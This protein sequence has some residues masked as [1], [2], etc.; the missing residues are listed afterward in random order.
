[1]KQTHPTRL[2]WLI[3]LILAT[4]AV[5]PAST[6]AQNP[7]QPH[8]VQPGDTWLALAWR[9]QTTPTNLQTHNPFLNTQRQPVIGDTIQVPDVPPQ[10]GRLIPTHSLLQ[11]A[12]QHNQNPWQL[13]LQNHLPHPH[14]PSFGRPL[15]VADGVSL[16]RQLPPQFATLELAQVPAFPGE[17]L[18][19]RGVWQG[20]AATLPTLTLGTAVGTFFH[21]PQNGAMVGLIGTGA[22]FRPGT[23]ELTIRTAGQPLWAQPWRISDQK[24][25]T[26]NQITLSGTAATIT[27]QQRAAER[28]RLFDLWAQHTPAPL[29]N[30]PF[31]EPISDYLSYSS[32]YGA[33]RSYNG[34]PYDSYHEG[35]D[36]AAFGGTEVYAPADGIVVLAEFLDVRGGAVIIDHGLGV[37][38]GFYHLSEVA[39][40]AIG[41]PIAQGE[42]LGAVGTTGLSTGNHLHWDLL[43]NGVWVDPMPWREQNLSAWLLTGWQ[44]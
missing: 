28:E 2:R 25:W 42:T 27:A 41:Q 13:A 30:Q 38:S 10:N 11:T 35:L 36:F 44:Q 33:R 37:F 6:R 23:P 4:T 1:M 39:D 21:N 34:G 3:W 5:L 8:L 31:I 32:F 9:Y 14:R 19:L 20:D 43:V 15:F 17:G 22:F 26:F 16:P 18:G 29:W 40:L 12:L 24:E 7:T